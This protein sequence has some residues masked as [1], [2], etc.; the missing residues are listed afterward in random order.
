MERAAGVWAESDS[1]LLNRFVRQGE[2]SA[3]AALVERHGPSVLG[4]C[5]RVLRNEHDAEDVSQGAFLVLARKAGRLDWQAS[6]RTW[7]CAVAYRLALNARSTAG[8]Q[9]GQEAPADILALHA[10]PVAVC[11]RRELRSLL[12]DELHRLP[13]KYRAPVVLC[14]L[15]G[16]TNQ[17]A[18]QLL[19]WPAGSMSRRLARARDLLH[20]RLS[21]RGLALVLLLGL[22]LLGW[23]SLS[24]PRPEATTTLAQVMSGLRQTELTLRR[25]AE[26]DDARIDLGDMQRL[27]RRTAAAADSI[28]GHD[29]GQG[30][31]E[32]AQHSAAVRQASEVLAE[33]VR[34]GKGEGDDRAIRRAA[35][36][37]YASC[38]HCHLAFR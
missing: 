14:Y 8:R 20:Q 23:W 31:Q 18:A 27:A 34:E 16:K 24:G 7:L 32:W 29:P 30:R 21:E 35:R 28:Q 26:S 1:Q 15:E 22:A 36:N 5:R 10:D 25:T 37:L 9:R 6:V 33:S 4:V 11:E 2:D 12:D 17:E 38:Q 13:E 3:F 19:G